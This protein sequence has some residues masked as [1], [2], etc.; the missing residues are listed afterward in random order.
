MKD[1]K[2]SKD[3]DRLMVEAVQGGYS[4]FAWN[5]VGGVVE[6]CG[7]KIKAYRKDYNEIELEMIPGEEEK[8]GKV[9][10]GNRILNIYV[11]EISVSFSSELKTVSADKKVKLYIPSDFSFYERRKHERVQPAKTCYVSFELNK[12]MVRKPIYDFSLGG[13]AFI[14]PKSD[15][16]IVSKGKT[17][18][19]FVIEI[20]FKKIKVKAVCVNSFTIDRFKHENLP[21]GGY[22][23][24]FRF[25]EISPE[26]RKFLMDFVT[27]EMIAQQVKKKAN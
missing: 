1:L 7:L 11:P 20:A 21:Y 13:I 17:F 9:I 5:S 18:D 22:K 3:F 12:Q 4:F 10:S 26:D 14:L 19:T 8:L 16:M 2:R 6:K 27:T 24:A 25:T 15:K 23:V